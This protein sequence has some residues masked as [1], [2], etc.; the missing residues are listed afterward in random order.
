M[1]SINLCLHVGIHSIFSPHLNHRAIFSEKS[2]ALFYWD[3]YGTYVCQYIYVCMYFL[4]LFLLPGTSSCSLAF[5]VDD[6]LC[7]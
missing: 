2:E 6:F 5:S 4:I 3:F 1:C 7:S